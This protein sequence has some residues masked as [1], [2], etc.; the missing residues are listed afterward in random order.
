MHCK[1]C[2]TLTVTDAKFCS[3]CGAAVA[4]E[5]SDEF[6]EE[7][8]GKA[9]I[10]KPR[11]IW[12]YVAG[13]LLVGAYAAMF[14]PALAGQSINPQSGF[15]SMLWTGLFFFLWW[16]QRGRSGS[17]GALIGTV[18]GILIFMLAAF[19]GGLMRHTGG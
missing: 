12:L 4:G 15:G 9:D 14:L 11:R 3:K 7:T 19:V 1:Q 5:V 8:M 10:A 18:V 17:R 6:P 16:R 13:V 2:G